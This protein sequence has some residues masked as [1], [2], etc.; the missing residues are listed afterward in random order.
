MYNIALTDNDTKFNNK[1]KDVKWDSDLRWVFS[2][3]IHNFLKRI[4]KR[5]ARNKNNLSYF[6]PPLTW[7]SLDKSVKKKNEI[8]KVGIKYN[9]TWSSSVAFSW[10]L[11]AMK[12]QLSLALFLYFF[13]YLSIYECVSIIAFNSNEMLSM[14]LLLSETPTMEPMKLTVIS[15]FHHRRPHGASSSGPF[16]L[17]LKSLT[18]RPWIQIRFKIQDKD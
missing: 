14:R 12:P 2:F 18:T 16:V 8:N 5:I 11:L 13:L 1:T 3:Q 6:Y 17:K 15:N 4:T 9:K 7:L 10:N